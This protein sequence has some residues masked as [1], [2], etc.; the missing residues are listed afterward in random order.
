MKKKWLTLVLG[1][2]LV[3]APV[4]IPGPVGAL[5]SAIAGTVLGVPVA[6]VRDPHLEGAP[7]PFVN[8]RCE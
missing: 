1:V 3:A 8:R 4:V 5:L 6:P 7:L 2:V